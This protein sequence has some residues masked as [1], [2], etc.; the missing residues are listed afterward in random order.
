M[1]TNTLI[2]PEFKTF[3]NLFT[4]SGI[5]D[6]LRHEINILRKLYFIEHSTYQNRHLHNWLLRTQ[7]PTLELGDYKPCENFNRDLAYE[8][9][10]DYINYFRLELGGW[11][12]E[13]CGHQNRYDECLYCDISSLHLND[14]GENMLYENE[15]DITQ[16]HFK[17][18]CFKDNL[19]SNK[20]NQLSYEEKMEIFSHI[21]KSR[22]EWYEREGTCSVFSYGMWMLDM[23]PSY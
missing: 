6:F 23:R 4:Q 18:K 22:I 10:E 8:D 1:T 21:Y 19:G 5:G 2:S 16:F 20:F 15:C 13:N 11:I 3:L 17:I 9:G 7:L 14:E 12:C